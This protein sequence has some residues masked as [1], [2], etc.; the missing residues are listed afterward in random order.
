M[1]PQ[2]L[3]PQSI[4]IEDESFAPADPDS[5]AVVN[6]GIA[7]LRSAHAELLEAF[8]FEGKTVQEIAAERSLSERAVE[9]RL[10]RARSVLRKKLT[11]SHRDFK[12]ESANARQTPAR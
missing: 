10:R 5:A 8:Y 11:A 3:D 2:Q 12:G 9:G 1:R 4:R 6:W 7:R